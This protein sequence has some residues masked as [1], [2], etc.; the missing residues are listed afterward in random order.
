MQRHTLTDAWRV[1]SELIAQQIEQIFSS[2]IM[3]INFVIEKWPQMQQKRCYFTEHL[4]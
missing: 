3:Y 4:N 1:K 2:N